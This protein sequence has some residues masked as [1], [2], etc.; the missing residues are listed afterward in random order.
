[1]DGALSAAWTAIGVSGVLGVGG[2][3]AVYVR[4]SRVQ[5]KRDGRL[6]Q[7]IDGLCKDITD[8]KNHCHSVTN[9]FDKRIRSTEIG[10]AGQQ[11]KKRG[12]K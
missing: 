2:W 11:P 12:G 8:M 10:L 7:K 1:M 6:E 9:G 3:V 5:A 4:G